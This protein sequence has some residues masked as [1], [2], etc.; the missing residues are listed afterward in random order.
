MHVLMISLDSRLATQPDSNSTRRHIDYAERAGKLTI[1]VYTPPG[2][3]DPIHYSDPLTVIPTN[4]ASRL[5]FVPDALRLAR[6]VIASDKPDLITTQDPFAAGLVGW[7]ARN[8]SDVPVLVQNHCYFIDNEAWLAE[9][10]LRN[11]AFNALGKFISVRADVYRTVNEHERDTYLA[12]GGAPE[13]VFT[14]PLGTASDAFTQP[15]PDDE[16]QR[17][18]DALD[19]APHHKVMIWAGFPVAFKRV[20]LLLEVF[21]Q[22]AAQEPDARLLLLGDM[23]D[24]SD[25]IPALIERLGIDDSVIAPGFVPHAELPAYYG[26]ADV[27]LMTSAYEGIPRVLMEASAAGLPMVAFDRVGVREVIEDGANGRLLPEGDVN[28]MVQAVLDLLH[29]PETAHRLGVCARERSV[30]RFSAAKNADNVI[31]TWQQAVDLGLRR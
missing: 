12:R 25:D 15:P 9:R 2:T 31:Q 30:Q 20:P 4:S 11:R 14:Y 21:A 8:H 22:I 6:Q 27:Y 3:G 10:P 7:L 13:R 28:G 26:I 16:L 23:S 29:D 24:S 19:I 1:V 17:V 5:T 18:R